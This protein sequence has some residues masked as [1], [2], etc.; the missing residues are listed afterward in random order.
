MDDDICRGREFTLDFYG[1]QSIF[2]MITAI[3]PGLCVLLLAWI[4]R[5]G[6]GEGDGLLLM[7]IGI[8]LGVADVLKIFYMDCFYPE[9]MRPLYLSLEKRTENM[10][11]LLYRFYCWH[12]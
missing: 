10:R 7:V 9:R 5:G 2:E 4:T 1:E 12:L 11:L 6:I 3:C 8:F